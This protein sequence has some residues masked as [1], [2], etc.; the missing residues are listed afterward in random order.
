MLRTATLR[1][2]GGVRR[3]VARWWVIVVF[4]EPCGPLRAIMVGGLGLGFGGGKRGG[5][6]KSRMCDRRGLAAVVVD[7]IVRPGLADHCRSL[8]IWRA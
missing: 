8:R 7:A 3:A 4:P 5:E 2:Y 1:E 6:R